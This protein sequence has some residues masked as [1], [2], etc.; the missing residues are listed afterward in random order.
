MMRYVRFV[1]SSLTGMVVS[2]VGRGPHRARPLDL[3]PFTDALGAMTDDRRNELDRVLDD[4]SVAAA[5]ALLADGT[6]TA[7]ELAL[8]HL[9]RIGRLDDDLGTMLELDPS[10]LDAARSSDD[11][12]RRGETLGPLDGIPVTIK[13][14]IETAG[15]VRTTGGAAV[16][17][18]HVADADAPVV[19]LLRRAGA[20]VLGTSNLSELAGAVCKTPGVSALG[21][22]TRN[23]HGAELSPGGSSSGSAAGV[24]AEL[25]VLSVGTE[26]S[27]SLVAPA[28]FN[29]V[30][31]MKPSRGV[32]DGS[33]VIPLLA[34]N[35][36]P[37]PI[38]RSVAD[39]AALL[40]VLSDGTVAASL[41]DDALAGVRVGVLRADI[42]SASSP[43]ED[44]SDQPA[45]LQRILD[46]L[47]AA[48]AEVADTTLGDTEAATAFERDLPKLVF[49]GLAWETTAYLRDAGTSI[50]T[51]ADLQRFNLAAPNVRMPA[52]QLLL[53]LATL[54]HG[55][56]DEHHAADEQHVARAAAL[57]DAAFD[58][59]DAEVL[60]STS[61]RHAPFY[62]SAGYP[63][64]TVPVGLHADGGPAGA[65]FIGRPGADAALVAYAHAF[66]QAT[67]LRV[68]PAIAVRG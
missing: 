29:G 28:S 14:N 36:S 51:L 54:L 47:A 60:A 20:V 56:Q 53:D 32:V 11:R 9:D 44:S 59:V 25:T 19:T 38:G 67:R 10:A 8:H 35:D 17:A 55:A 48:G 43:F 33:G 62:A 61:A 37:G 6:L 57:L 3:S 64:V 7:E 58:A 24:A 50:R 18:D 42:A 16:L 2:A 12:R 15:P 66:E 5:Q 63:A 39:V 52:G 40:A 65:T 21:G 46:G 45:I 23:P 26:T 27:G 4:V 68:R 22:A 31:G 13:G 49:G 34:S 41:S 1:R 30:V